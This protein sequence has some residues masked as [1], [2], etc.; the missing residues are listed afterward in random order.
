MRKFT[1]CSPYALYS[2]G[3]ELLFAEE[4]QLG[5]KDQQQADGSGSDDFSN[6]VD[7]SSKI[8]PFQQYQV[9]VM[10]KGEHD[11]IRCIR[12]PSHTNNGR[13]NIVLIGAFL[14]DQHPDNEWPDIGDQR[15]GGGMKARGFHEI[16]QAESE[17]EAYKGQ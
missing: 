13:G 9:S 16:V 8:H 14:G 17:N 12:S 7:K 10:Q 5:Q 15:A 11:H 6:E 3:P 1:F 4:Q 2:I